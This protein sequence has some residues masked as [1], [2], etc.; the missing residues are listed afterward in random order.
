MAEGVAQDFQHRPDG[1]AWSLNLEDG[2]VHRLIVDYAVSLTFSND[3]EVQIGG[4]FTY[5]AADGSSA[6]YD[7]EGDPVL[8]GPVLRL[9]RIETR[10]GYAFLDGSLELG[11]ADGSSVHVAVDEHYEAWTLSGPRGFKLVS[12]PGGGLA[13]WEQVD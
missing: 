5:A 11:F 12:L 2:L 3:V 10:F 7:P 9:S 13:E 6:T 1:L 8:L 4:I